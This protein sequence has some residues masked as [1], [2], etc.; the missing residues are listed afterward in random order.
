MG[1]LYNKLPKGSP[2][3]L[4]RSM[5][6]QTEGEY[7]NPTLVPLR[8][9]NSAIVA[10]ISAAASNIA[11]GLEVAQIKKGIKKE[12][13]REEQ[14]IK[15]ASEVEKIKENIRPSGIKIVV[16]KVSPSTDLI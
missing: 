9:D 3:K 5:V 12:K 11:A 16:S 10:G 13:E 7:A 8:S 14:K 2:I 4:A 15:N 6:P 1:S